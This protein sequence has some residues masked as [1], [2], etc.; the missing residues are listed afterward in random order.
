MNTKEDFCNLIVSLN[1]SILKLRVGFP[2]TTDH[3]LKLN[4]P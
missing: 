2:K 1:Y 3:D 4:Q